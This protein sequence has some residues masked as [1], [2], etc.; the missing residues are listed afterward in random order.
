MTDRPIPSQMVLETLEDA[1]RRIQDFTPEE[2][3]EFVQDFVACMHNHFPLMDKQTEDP[4][5]L[6][7]TSLLAA[8]MFQEA[9]I[10]AYTHAEQRVDAV[11]RLNRLY[12]S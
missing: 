10:K 7:Y 1:T 11:E 5:V 8:G 6:A 4:V 9:F 12:E 2:A 3:T